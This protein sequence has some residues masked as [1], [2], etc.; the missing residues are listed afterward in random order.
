MA[1]V[2]K[3][4]NQKSAKKLLETNGWVKT[5]GG[6]HNIK[7]EKEGER[8]ITLPMHRGQDYSKALSRAILKQ[9]GLI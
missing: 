9:A 8:P 7:M 4:I 2:P 6:K 1:D 3:I 5:E